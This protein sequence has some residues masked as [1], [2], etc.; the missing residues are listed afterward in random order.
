MRYL[1]ISASI[2]LGG[3]NGVFGLDEGE[4]GP[5]GASS[6]NT[7]STSTGG[8][9]TGGANTG[10]ANT[11]GATTSTAGG[12]GGDC[13]LEMGLLNADFSLHDADGPKNWLKFAYAT[14]VTLTPLPSIETGLSLSFTDI[15]NANA[16]GGIYQSDH[17]LDPPWDQCVVMYGDARRPTGA[18]RL[19]ARASF[20]GHRLGL[21]LPDEANFV[22][23]YE[24]CRIP[25]PFDDFQVRLEVDELP[26]GGV[27]NF[28]MNG[29]AFN[30]AC[31]KGGEPM[32]EM[33]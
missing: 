18:G 13:T 4:L 17:F 2:L 10:G 5:G 23:F 27:A 11:G 7:A 15:S 24:T 30:H 9:N 16:N 21:V 25:I 32:C 14:S 8:T 28:Q 1:W 20:G 3:C 19:S 6:M 29:I 26:P 22:S 31:C 33:Q 12:M